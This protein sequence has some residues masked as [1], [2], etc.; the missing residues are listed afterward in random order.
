VIAEVCFFKPANE[1]EKARELISCHP[2]RLHDPERI[3]E[4]R[5]AVLYW[6]FRL[7]RALTRPIRP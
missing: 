1:V 6:L 3:G 4:D 5:S 7:E 2:N